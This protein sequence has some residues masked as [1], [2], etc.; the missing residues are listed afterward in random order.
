MELNFEMPIY[1]IAFYAAGFFIL[2]V[3]GVSLGISLPII[4]FITALLAV[5]FL[6]IGF[7]K[8]SKKMFWLVGLS[9]VIIMGAFYFDFRDFNREENA[10]I[11]FNEKINFQGLVIKDPKRGEWQDLIIKLTTPY[12][13]NISVKLPFSIISF[14]SFEAEVNLRKSDGTINI[15]SP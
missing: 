10:K 4:L 2:G 6:F 12:S 7:Y 1:D 11:V 14:N 5:L 9:L 3:F 15:N 8:N 13:G